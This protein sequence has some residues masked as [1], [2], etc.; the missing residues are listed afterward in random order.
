MTQPELFIIGGP[1][2]SGKTTTAVRYLR[3]TSLKFLSAD[4][5]AAELSPESPAL[6]AIAAGRLLSRR[7]TDALDRGESVVVE[8]TLSGLTLRR[9]IQRASGLGYRTTI[10]FVYVAS[11]DECIA[12][13]KERVAGGGHFVPDADVVRRFTRSLDNFWNEYRDLVSE[14]ILFDNG[15]L[16]PLQ[17]ASGGQRA[18]FVADE[19]RLADFLRL[20]GREGVQYDQYGRGL[21][22]S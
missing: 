5:I 6:A 18:V 20:I 22:Q 19:I 15:G 12:R 9:T 21:S 14:W 3:S 10:L 17:I 2:G 13:I 4:S 7:L 11:P 16:S 1:N 8:S